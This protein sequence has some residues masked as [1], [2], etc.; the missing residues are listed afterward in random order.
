MKRQ[1]ARVKK[2]TFLY[3]T[4]NMSTKKKHEQNR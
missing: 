1:F 3:K 2:F 4:T